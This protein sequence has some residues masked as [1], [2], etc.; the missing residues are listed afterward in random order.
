MGDK[1]GGL[2]RAQLHLD[3]IHANSTT[4]SFLF[5]ALA[6]LLDNAR[7]A[8]AARLDV[9]SVDNEKLQGG[10]M[11]CFLDDGC[12]MSPEEASDIIYFGTSKKRSSTL[13]FIGQY[14]NGLKSGSMRIGKDF[15]LF[16]KKEETMTC[17]FFSQTFCETEGLSE[18]V[19]PIPSWLTRTRESVTDDPQNFSIEL[20]IIFKYSPF[21]N[22]AEL[23]QQFDVIYGKCGTLLVIYNLKLLLS[24]EPE[25]DVKT[26]K[27]D[28]LVAG[29]LEDFPERWSFRAYTSVLYFE[30]WMRI[31]IQA[32]R[33]KT[34]HLC[35]CLYRPRKYLY[36]TSSFK[37]VFKNEVKKAEEAVKIANLVLKEAQITVNQPDRTS[38]SSAKVA[39][40]KALEDVEA[41]Y[42]TLKEK[43][44]ELRKA[45]TLCLFFGVNI[46]NRSQAGMFIYSNNRLIKMHEKVGPQLKLKSLFGA[47]VVGIVNIPLEIMEPSH[48]K[49]EFLNVRE[50][51]HLL[52]VM[53]QYLVQYC[54]DTGM[55]NRNLT[56]F[57]N[58]FGYQHNTDMEKSLD[59]I[60]Y[61]RRKALAIPFIIQCDL[62][63]KWRVLPSSIHYQEKEFFDLWICANNP[64]LLE[65]SCCQA[66]RLPSIPLGTMN[67]VSPSKTEKEKQLQEVVQ[68]YHS[69]LAEQ[70]PQE[71]TKTQKF[72]PWGDDLNEES[73]A[74]FELSVS[75][76]G[77]K[78]NTEGL[79]SDVEYVLDTKMKRSTQKK[80]KPQQHRH[81]AALPEN[82]RLAQRSQVLG[83]S[84][85]DVSLKQKKEVSLMKR[86]KQEL[87]SDNPE[88]KR[89]SSLPNRE[90][91]LMEDSSPGSGCNASFSVSG[92]CN[93]ASVLTKSSQ[94]TSIKE[95]VR[96]LSSKLREFILNFFPEYQ[97]PSGFGYTS[98]EDLAASFELEQCPE[99]INKKL[100]M[101]FNQIQNVYMVQ[102]ERELKRKIQS[103]TYDAN[104]RG[105]VNEISLRQCEEKRK[106]TEN[107]LN[108]LREKL[109]VLLQK[110][111]LGSPAG[112][113]EQIDGYLEALLKEDNPLFRNALNKVTTDAGHSLPL[114][115][116]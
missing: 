102:H 5:G 103:I 70:Q 38:L 8:G 28:I 88:I 31:F 112:D 7:D 71:S 24:G 60:Q 29:A 76:R 46:E 2:R 58:E 62:C 79:D 17:V 9:F 3:F 12:G 67:T 45:R 65:N 54:K 1:Y 25:L 52:R 109:A 115:K 108:S 61:Q 26:D 69:R 85:A 37:E 99:Q 21:R 40:Q 30:P 11:L 100:R 16:T 19:V 92:G 96:K 33:V 94:G 78:T 18:V 95:T 57:W 15:I 47:G 36:V 34:K 73:L 83:K 51:N 43:R 64:N 41:K 106:V 55:S 87:C 66:E 114:E 4:H 97:L 77:R 72:R 10:F 39:L 80:V 56:L 44:R 74:S 23:M 59:T 50:Y 68:R 48:N 81:P 35:Y 116:N 84:D 104:R 27:E 42:K 32:K 105:V 63:L 14:G 75:H 13:K 82:T 49:Q 93:V 91:A 86:E 110:F 89:N 98:V 20:S 101:C 53:G 90:S 22:E 111:Q 107:K 6:E 113:L